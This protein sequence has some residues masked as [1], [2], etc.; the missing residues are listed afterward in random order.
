MSRAVYLPTLKRVCEA[1]TEKREPVGYAILHT[2]S[3]PECD[4]FGTLRAG[5]AYKRD[6]QSQFYYYVRVLDINSHRDA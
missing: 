1:G 5:V 4:Q 3:C 6:I 2:K